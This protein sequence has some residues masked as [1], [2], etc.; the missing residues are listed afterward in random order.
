MSSP[1]TP[2]PPGMPKE[3]I[4]FQDLMRRYQEASGQFDE[5]AKDPSRQGEAL[6]AEQ[7]APD[8]EPYKEAP[9]QAPVLPMQTAMPSGDMM[10]QDVQQ[11]QNADAFAKGTPVNLPG[12]APA[13]GGALQNILSRASVTS[14]SAGQANPT[15]PIPGNAAPPDEFEEQVRKAQEAN[16]AEL[17]AAQDSDRMQKGMGQLAQAAEMFGQAFTRGDA[18]PEVLKMLGEGGK[19]VAVDNFK[20]KL[21]AKE[22]GLKN[23]L[24]LEQ[25]RDTVAK[26]KLN[27][28]MNDPGS[29]VSKLVRSRII[30]DNPGLASS[31]ANLSAA[32]LKEL[33]F[34]ID[35]EAM[36]EFKKLQLELSRERLED[37]RKK[38]G[39]LGEK[40]KWQ[41]DEKNEI[42]DKQTETV[43]N[44]K[45]SIAAL[46]SIGKKARLFDKGPV[47]D[48]VASMR[49]FLGNDNAKVTAFKAETGRMLANYMRSIS[50]SA[51]AEQ[52]AQRLSK[53]VPSPELSDASFVEVLKTFKE[54]LERSKR[55]TL[56]SFEQQGKN[57]DKFKT[58]APAQSNVI[59]RKTKDGRIALFDENKKFLGYEK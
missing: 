58:D 55:I 53:L 32:Q 43:N 33:G 27:K 48:R 46:D 10:P 15:V 49:R 16:V 22:K 13:Q 52:E 14:A 35:N 41:M 31:L 34:K 18:N 44:Y 36:M 45:L 57:V 7:V 38:E 25:A 4:D 29:D 39:R 9:S 42:S 47:A 40:Q 28:Q 30:K 21:D 2:V 11:A 19:G 51:I 50:G 26:V 5:F 8:L 3:G 12:Q 56:E 20:A 54:E 24:E 23:I 1:Y 6:L 17:K 59:K 37:A